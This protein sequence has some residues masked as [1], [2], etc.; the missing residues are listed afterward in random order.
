[1]QW[2]SSRGR[3]AE[4]AVSSFAAIVVFALIMFASFPANAAPDLMPPVTTVAPAGGFVATPQTVTLSVNEPATI[5]YTTNG[6]DPT[7]SSPQY[8]API[9]VGNTTTLKFFAV[10]TAGNYEL[11]KSA[12][13]IFNAAPSLQVAWQQTAGPYGGDIR[14][15]AADPSKTGTIYA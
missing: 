7:I 5:Y 9:T 6:S 1:M 4:K 12:T 11:T 3:S 10:D 2:L 14:A 8:A 15:L 13:Y